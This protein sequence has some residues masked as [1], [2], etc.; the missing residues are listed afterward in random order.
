M[1]KHYTVCGSDYLWVYKNHIKPYVVFKT[2][3]R[4]KQKQN[5]AI[6]VKTEFTT[7]Y[8]G[9]LK[10]KDNKNDMKTYSDYSWFICSLGKVS[11][12]PTKAMYW[13]TWNDGF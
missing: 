6:V 2:W 4:L 11:W 5:L 9:S 3:R 7:L 1:P 12:V 13:A 10:Y 8:F